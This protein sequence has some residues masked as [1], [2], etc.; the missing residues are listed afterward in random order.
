MTLRRSRTL[1]ISTNPAKTDR[2]AEQLYERLHR[3]DPTQSAAPANLGAYR[4]QQG[5]NEEAIRLFQE[6]LRISPGLVLARLDLAVALDSH[7][8]RGRSGGRAQEGS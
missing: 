1:P 3:V 7:G 4:M 8:T 6:A 5:R 2:T